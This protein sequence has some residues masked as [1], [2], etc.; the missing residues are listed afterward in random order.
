LIKASFLRHVD[1][2]PVFGPQPT[3]TMPYSTEDLGGG[4]A[5]RQH[6]DV[7]ESSLRE[8]ERLRR[9]LEQLRAS[10]PPTGQ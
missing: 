7:L 8:I 3:F 10:L 4:S 2:E 6:H 1:G 9:E 5:D